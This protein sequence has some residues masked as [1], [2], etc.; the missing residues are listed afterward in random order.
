MSSVIDPDQHAD[1]VRLQ[2]A[3]IAAHEA[4]QAYATSVGKPALEWTEAE[5]ARSEELREA[6]RQASAAKDEALHASGLP[7]EHGYY[8]ASVDLRNAARED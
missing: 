1:L 3:A 2:R 4:L 7:A 8:R 5:H 6:A